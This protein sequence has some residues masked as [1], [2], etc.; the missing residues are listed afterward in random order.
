MSG[1]FGPS[2]LEGASGRTDHWTPAE[3]ARRAIAGAIVLDV[4][5]CSAW[6]EMRVGA[7]FHLP[8]S[9]V[10]RRM[11]EIPAG[12]LVCMCE[13]GSQSAVVSSLLRA[14]GRSHVANL[15]GGVTA[16]LGAGLPV[17]TEAHAPGTL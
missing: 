2:A 12:P 7:S 8:M 9:E 16:W 11:P 4:R 17:D 3:A 6:E 5:G 1:W 13:T 10:A 14:H 15:T